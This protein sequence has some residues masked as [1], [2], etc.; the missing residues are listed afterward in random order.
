MSFWL[1]KAAFAACAFIAFM[2]LAQVQVVLAKT[3]DVVCKVSGKT[4]DPATCLRALQARL[5]HARA[6]AQTSSAKTSVA[7][8]PSSRAAGK[9]KAKK[10]EEKSPNPSVRP[11]LRRSLDDIDSFAS[12]KAVADAAGAEFSWTRDGITGNRSWAA[13]GVAALPFVWEN[14][15]P[16]VR[17]GYLS[18]VML[19]PYVVFDRVTNTEDTKKNVN[20]L[21]FG[22]VGEAAYANLWNATHYFRLRSET[23]TTFDVSRGKNWAVVGEYQPIGNPEQGRS[24][25]IFAYLGTPL[26]I[27]RDVYYSITP[28]LKAEYRS[29]IDGGDDPIFATRNEAFRTGPTVTG[30]IVVDNLF[31]NTLPFYSVVYQATYSWLWDWLSQRDYRLFD[32]AL[33]FNLTAEG[34]VG[35]TL[36]YRRGELEETGAPVEVTQVGL[37]LKF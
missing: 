12:P 34:N 20:N 15:E 24:N 35:L 25:S 33:T 26:P 21:V 6:S 18:N 23:V 19:A 2:T 27:T 30:A 29:V 16:A 37:A 31:N 11:L 5:D 36:S 17:R 32:T 1:A 3:D 13:R 7:G 28:K 14:P 10:E 9:A 4:V 22:F 8:A